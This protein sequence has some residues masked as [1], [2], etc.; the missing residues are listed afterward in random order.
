[1]SAITTRPRPLSTPPSPVRTSEV[2]PGERR[3]LIRGLSWDLYDRLSD[4][5]GEGQHIRLA[6]DGRNLEIMTTGVLH[7]DFK[8]LLG[9]LVNNVTTELDIPCNGGGQTT[10]KRPEI[11][12]GLESDQCYYFTPEKMA[13]VA[14][15]RA[16][17]S[18]A[19]A[20]Y[21]NPDLAIEVDISP[22]ELDRAGIYAAL[23]VAEVWRFDGE[24]LAI[25]HLQSDGRYTAVESSQFLPISPDEILRWVAKEDATNK[26][27]WERR[28][29]AWIRDDLAPR[30]KDDK[31]V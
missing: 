30:F 14:E 9:R 3:I 26:S 5:I 10:W 23:K 18:N 7:E 25:M 8:D 6:F 13:A 22:P 21:P 16:R 20:D 19:V 11:L 29:R 28:L 2:A 17:K 1:M 12:R 31:A 15:A 4:E 27:S 24:S